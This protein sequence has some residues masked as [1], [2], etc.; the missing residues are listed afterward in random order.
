MRLKNFDIIVAMLIVVINVEW[1]Q[2]PDHPLAIGIILALPLVLLLPGYMLTQTLFGNPS[3][4]L[5]PSSNLI[6]QPR[7]KI[8]QQINAADQIVLSLGLSMAIDVVVGFALNILPIG[9]QGLSW[10]LSLGIITTVFALFVMFLRRKVTSRG[11]R[12]SGPRIRIFE[13]ILFALAI[14]VTIVAV[15]FSSIRPPDPQTS[16]TQFWLF[17]TKNNSCGI[18]IGVQSFETTSVTYRIL[19]TNNG[20]KIASWSSIVLSPQQKWEQSISLKSETVDTM[21]IEAQLYRVDKPETVY[22]EV[23]TT[24]KDSKNSKDQKMLC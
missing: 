11:A 14:F 6:L 15:W 17:S 7:L 24:L 8:G 23:H 13:Y 20:A 5:V 9:L 2:I 12:K 10:T 19:I 18:Q 22:R 16:F 1:I 21:Y 4:T 3:P